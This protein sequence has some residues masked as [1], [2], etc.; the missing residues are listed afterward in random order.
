M[1]QIT[2]EPGKQLSEVLSRINAL[3]QQGR[4]RPAPAEDS[5]P[6]LTESYNGHQPLQFIDVASAQLP[7]LRHGL[8][9]AEPEL[10]GTQAHGALT[11]A[12]Q[13]HLLS[14]MEP[15]IQAAIKKAIL[16]ELVIIEKALKTKLERDLMEALKQ[17]IA[18][19]QY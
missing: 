13:Q 9:E 18:S 8:N 14:E 16:S 1:S 5:I 17:R 11:P 2:A 4:A 15:L 10:D 3:T 7:I 12:Q 6:R 19:G